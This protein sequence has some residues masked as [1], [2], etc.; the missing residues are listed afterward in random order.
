[1]PV[2]FIEFMAKNPK[3]S[4]SLEK[5]ETEAIQ[6][7]LTADPVVALSDLLYGV[8]PFCRW[9]ALAY[10]SETRKEPTRRE[11]R[12][13]EE[14]MNSMLVLGDLCV[15][16]PL[17]NAGEILVLG[18]VIVDGPYLTGEEPGAKLWVGGSLSCD[19][20]M[21]YEGEVLSCKPVHVGGVTALIQCE[22]PCTLLTS[23]LSTDVLI[24][25]GGS[26]VGDC[27]AESR[28]EN[29]GYLPYKNLGFNFDETDPDFEVDTEVYGP[30]FEF[31]LSSERPSG[32]NRPAAC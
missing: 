11:W 3:W 1:M 4:V 13:D 30:L 14:H 24:I 25:D 10:L 23:Q 22:A 32:R 18:D 6:L 7:A 2:S 28:F 15:Q 21:N 5:P 26:L 29:Q 31:L 19:H 8:R 12:P 27:I 9:L 20:I 16:G 17:V